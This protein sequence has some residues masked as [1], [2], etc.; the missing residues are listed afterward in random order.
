MKGQGTLT[1]PFPMRPVLVLVS[2]YYL[3]FI[4]RIVL[5]PMLPIIE[6]DVGLSHGEAG[7]LFLFITGGYAAG[8]FGSTFLASRLSHRKMVVL[9][10][11]GV[12][13]AMLAMS[14]SS[15]IPEMHMGLLATGVFAGFYLPSGMAI[16]TEL[17][18]K[19][20][21]GKAMAINELAPTLALISTPLFVEALLTLLPWHAVLGVVGVSS[22]VLGAFFLVFGRGGNQTGEPPHPAT[23]KRI[24]RNSSFW[25][26]ALALTLSIGATLGVYTMLPLFLVNEIGFDRAFANTLIGFSRVLG[27]VMLFFSGMITDRIG[28]K[29]GTISFLAIMGSL[30]LIL[31]VVRGP[32]ATPTLIVLQATSVPCLFAAIFALISSIFPSSHRSLGVSLFV[33]VGFLVGTGFVPPAIGYLAETLSFSFGF[34]AVGIASVST[35][36]LLIYLKTDSPF[37]EQK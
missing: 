21:W 37:V 1:L 19:K 22:V 16:L 14:R 13:G 15:S 6:V 28:H 29:R 20:H 4:S 34:S 9:S 24:L 3:N 18:S 27:V 36:P 35:L 26:I 11:F 8:L 10:A 7:F 23:M 2:I 32:I 30:T 17:V 12:G 5:A 31:G 33:L 25:I